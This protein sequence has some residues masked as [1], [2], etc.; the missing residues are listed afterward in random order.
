[1]SDNER[2]LREI[3]KNSQALLESLDNLEAEPYFQKKWS[4]DYRTNVKWSLDLLK[5]RYN[6]VF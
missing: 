5:E 2:Q 3:V 1:M 4:R 6:Y